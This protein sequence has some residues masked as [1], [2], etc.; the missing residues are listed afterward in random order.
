DIW[1]TRLDQV[2]RV[3][4]ATGQRKDL[5]LPEFVRGVVVGS[6]AILLRS[7][8]EQQV[9]RISL[10]DGSTNIEPMSRAAMATRASTA[11][12]PVQSTGARGLNNGPSSAPAQLRGLATRAATSPTEED[13]APQP[14]R[15]ANEPPDASGTWLV[16][17]GENA[18]QFS[19]SLVQRLTVTHEAL[20]KRGKSVLDNQ[21]VTASQG[22]DLAEEMMNDQKRDE[23][24]GVDIEDVSL[25]GVT[26][27]RLF[28]KGVPDLLLT[29]T[30]PPRFIALK[31]VDLLVAGTN[32]IVLDKNNKELW[33][34]TLAFLTRERQSYEAENK[35]P[36]LET[37]DALYFADKGVLT[38]FD[39]NTGNVRWR[40]PTVGVSEITAGDH[41]E[42]YVATSTATA[43]SIR[44]SQQV[45]LKHRVDLVIMRV[46]PELGKVMWN[47]SFESTSYRVLP[48]GKFLYSVHEWQEQDPLRMEDGPDNKFNIK[49]IKPS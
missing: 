47:K 28:A 23:T 24:G 2:V 48:A 19:A 44:Y 8:V 13:P 33:R 26:V 36:C 39:L 34:S 45:D 10:A 38:R 30:G 41:G 37:K 22:I 27:H 1:V 16:D 21:N 12:R 15:V 3:D 31:K 7:D 43:E 6:D 20:K 9:T 11:K 49:L 25:Y 29:V 46:D 17:A 14:T 5:A 18:V 4:R 40:L 35:L 32:L 42:L